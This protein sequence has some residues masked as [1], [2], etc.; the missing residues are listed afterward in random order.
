MRK[1][2]V[3]YINNKKRCDAV[4]DLP[5]GLENIKTDASDHITATVVLNG[6]RKTFSRSYGKQSRFKLT[7]DQ[8]IKKCVDWRALEIE[9][10]F[11]I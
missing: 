7:K 10:A 9:L 8:A 3:P 2:P 4:Q 6:Q 11:I 1:K 5:V